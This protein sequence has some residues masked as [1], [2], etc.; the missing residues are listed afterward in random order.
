MKTAFKKMLVFGIGVGLMGGG[1]AN[2]T[3][4]DLTTLG[5]FRSLNGAQFVQT[6]VQP[7]GTGVIEP[8]LRIQA[9]GTEQGYNT[10][11]NNPPFDA[12]AGTW[13]HDLL[14]SD[15]AAVNY[16]GSD[17]YQFLLDINQNTGGSN[18]NLLSLDSLQIYLGTTKSPT[19][20]E[21]SD[22]GTMIYDLGIGN[23][24]LLNYDLNHGTGSGDMLAY[25]P[26]SLFTGSPSQ[27]VYL[28]SSFG[29]AYGSNDGGEEWAAT[30]APVP[31][32]GT[33]LL[34][35]AGFFGLAVYGKRLKVP[36]RAT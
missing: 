9:N 19:I 15:L 17:Y 8:F 33:I 32:P 4:I 34:L 26:T 21:I 18:N 16:H 29:S 11:A 3:T 12:K 28:Y 2:A 22:L 35:G 7:T 27:N 1:A 24:I 13:T 23:S 6:S 5:S 31:E 36:P 30:T 14:L 10:S 20:T 25:I